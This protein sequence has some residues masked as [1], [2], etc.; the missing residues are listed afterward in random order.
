MGSHHCPLG[1]ITPPYSHASEAEWCSSRGLQG[2]QSCSAASEERTWWTRKVSLVPASSSQQSASCL[3]H[4]SAAR[5]RRPVVPKHEVRCQEMIPGLSGNSHPKKKPQSILPA[6]HPGLSHTK[7]RQDRSSQ[8]FAWP[9]RL[10]R[11]GKLRA[12]DA[13]EHWTGVNVVTSCCTPAARGQVV[14]SM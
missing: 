13:A 10:V 1:Q 3:P 6:P 11:M 2:A 14:R 9:D 5:D 8:A 12:S 7:T 4:L